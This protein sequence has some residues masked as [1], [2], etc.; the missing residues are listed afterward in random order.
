MS[1]E[2]SSELEQAVRRVQLGERDA[3]REVVQAMLPFVRGFVA[4]RSLPGI[5]V[6]D[7]VQRTFVEAFQ[8]IGQFT[9]GTNLRAWMLTIA[10]Y[11]LMMETTRLKR[12]TDYH[13]RY[14]P[15]ALAKAT[16]SQLQNEADE[17][18]RAGHLWECLDALPEH[19]RQVLRERYEH[20]RSFAQMAALLGRTEGA[21][22]KQLCLLRQQLHDCVTRKLKLEGTH[23]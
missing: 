11:Q 13:A 20:D 9:A 6:D 21:I 1:D 16:E 23:E 7:V 3:F 22:R 8:S 4:G 5:D 12:L 19:A 18:V 14:V 2:Q 15:V 17:D 10:R